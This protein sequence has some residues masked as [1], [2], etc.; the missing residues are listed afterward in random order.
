MEDF[1][2]KALEAFWNAAYEDEHIPLPEVEGIT[3]SRNGRSVTFSGPGFT[4]T[5]DLTNIVQVIEKV[6]WHLGWSDLIPVSQYSSSYIYFHIAEDICYELGD[7]IVAFCK[8]LKDEDALEVL[9]VIEDPETPEK[10]AEIKEAIVLL[11]KLDKAVRKK[12]LP[13][14]TNIFAEKLFNGKAQARELPLLK[15]LVEMVKDSRPLQRRKCIKEAAELIYRDNFLDLHK[16]I[17]VATELFDT[18]KADEMCIQELTAHLA[19]AIAYSAVQRRAFEYAIPFLDH[20]VEHG[21]RF[22]IQHARRWKTRLA[23]GLEGAEDDWKVFSDCVHRTAELCDSEKKQKLIKDL[24][25]F[26]INGLL[27]ASESALYQRDGWPTDEYKRK[28]TK[29]SK[30][31][32]EDQQKHFDAIRIAT[33]NEALQL[34]EEIEINEAHP[35]MTLLGSSFGSDYDNFYKSENYENT[36]NW[37]KELSENG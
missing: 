3:F 22:A 24:K 28:K 1:A 29:K 31:V 9:C 32:P 15:S 4:E 35:S 37:L 10:N 17:P 20:C 7:E 34:I 33:A 11:K 13:D 12:L 27:R 18:V 23:L 5:G 19:G 36:C 21:P 26:R 8:E 6:W 25:L 14:N 30:P 16:I 2:Q